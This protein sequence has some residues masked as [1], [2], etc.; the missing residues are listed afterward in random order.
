MIGTRLGQYRIDALL[1]QGGMGAVYLATDEMLGR[2]VAIKV[3]RGDVH[4][5]GTAT[6]RFRS[7]AQILSRLDHPHILR[8]YGFSEHDGVLYMVTEYVKGEA[9]LRWL[10]RHAAVDVP[11]AV[12]WASQVLDA[13]DYAHQLGVVHRDIK[14]ANILIDERNRARLLDFGIARIAGMDGLTR[15]GQAVGTLTYMAPEQVLDEPIDGRVDVYAFGVV[16]CQM[17]AGRR[18]HRAT[19]TAGLLREI[20]EGPTPDVAA[21]LPPQAAPFAPL[22]VRALARH[23]DERTPSAAQMRLELHQAVAEAVSPP[24]LPEAP[25]AEGL[26]AVD[27]AAAAWSGSVA[28]PSSTGQ[29]STTGQTSTTQAGATIPV[30]PPIRRRGPGVLAL[31]VPVLLVAGVTLGWFAFGRSRVATPQTGVETSAPVSTADA[32]TAPGAPLTDTTAAVPA[33]RA[34]AME[35]P[36]ASSRPV[37]GGPPPPAAVA[38]GTPPPEA[39]RPRDTRPVAPAERQASEPEDTGAE[40]T[41][42]PAPAPATPAPAR[43]PTVEFKGMILIDRIDDE[44]EEIDVKVRL[45]SRR[46]V[47]VDEDNNAKR[48]IAYDS[49]ARASY[50][51][52]KPGRFSF[53]RGPSHWLTLEIGITPVVLRMNSKTYE[54]LLTTLAARGVHVERHQ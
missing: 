8:L 27:P 38:H 15:T 3:L 19:T 16:L 22:L 33:A 23:R 11:Q 29:V 51:T 47:V 42:P 36:A 31:A 37:S 35:A 46:V 7:E 14:P 20:I 54:Q 9:L 52:K 26:A 12:E 13:L 25:P 21:M 50:T 48:S 41:P 43:G 2:Q 53:R 39:S 32:G 17:L 1:G 45:D 49:I 24:P 10:E 28:V 6:E 5:E 30:P 18:P 44:D 34:P 4:S 40:A